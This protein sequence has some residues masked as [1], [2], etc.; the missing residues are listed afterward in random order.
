VK[1]EK[2]PEMPRRAFEREFGNK[3]G[4]AATCHDRSMMLLDVRFGFLCIGAGTVH[5]L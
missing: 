3:T 1:F 4:R 5:L 2:T